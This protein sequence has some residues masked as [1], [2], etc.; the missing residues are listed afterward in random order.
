MRG[1]TGLLGLDKLAKRQRRARLRLDMLDA[2]VYAVGDVHGCLDQ[3]LALERKIIADAHGLPESRKLI[4][5]LGDYVD[6]GPASAQVLEHLLEP[7]PDRFERICLA[8]NHETAM[9]DFFDGRI[10]LSDWMRMGAHATLV[11]YGIDPSR[12]AMIDGF[13]GRIESMLRDAIPAAHISFLRSLP[14]LV[15]ASKFLF[16]HAGIRPDKELAL[17]SDDDLVS[18][19]SAF[20]E[21]VHLLDRIVV[22]GHTPVSEPKFEGL[23]LNI[24]TCAYST[25]RLTAVRLWRNKGRFLTS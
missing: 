14:V 15:E 4:I 20:F 8:G 6:R 11:S 12:L 1:L 21:N 16:V 17:Q 5:M 3:L 25:G 13:G 10:A 23:R 9:L 19:R 7:P 18:I 22:H 2:A 24:D